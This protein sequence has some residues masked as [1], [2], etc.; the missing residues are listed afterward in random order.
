MIPAPDSS[1]R[2]L[3]VSGLPF[4]S[5]EQLPY[6]CDRGTYIHWQIRFAIARHHLNQHLPAPVHT[7]QHIGGRGKG[8]P[9]CHTVLLK[10]LGI[11][12]AR[13][14]P[15]V[16]QACVTPVHASIVARRIRNAPQS[17]LSPCRKHLGGLQG[18]CRELLKAYAIPSNACQTTF[19]IAPHLLHG[20]RLQLS[21]FGMPA[22]V[23]AGG[24]FVPPGLR[25][26]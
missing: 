1:R 2:A 11:R 3:E 23:R 14:P 8:G 4:S 17:L 9:A 15:G 7:S 10:A 20:M 24:G 25:K 18:V 22:P 12:T 5:A 26:A 6:L 19:C 13:L 21:L 16:T